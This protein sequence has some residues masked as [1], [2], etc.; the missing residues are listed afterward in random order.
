MG[1]GTKDSVRLETVISLS[2]EVTALLCAQTPMESTF[3]WH[4]QNTDI[5]LDDYVKARRVALGQSLSVKKL[6]YLDTN[7]WITLHEAAE[8]TDVEAI[9]FRLL[10]ALRN[11]V[12]TG[13]VL[14]PISANIFI[15]LMKQTD[16]RSRQAKA[17]LIDEL[18]QGVALMDEEERVSLEV[19]YFIQ[20]K[21]PGESLYPLE[22]LV[23]CKLGYVFGIQ[24]PT[25]TAFEPA[26]ERVIQKVCFDRMWSA[27]MSEIV[28]MVNAIEFTRAADFG[29]IA[30]ELN[31]SNQLYSADL[32]TFAKTNSDEIRGVID[33]QGAAILR[34][35]EFQAR[36]QGIAV[37]D[38]DENARLQSVTPFKNAMVFALEGNVKDARHTLRTLHIH[39]S[40]NASVR[41]NKSR[42][43]KPNDILDFHHAAAAL[44]YCDAF[45]KQRVGTGQISEAG[46]SSTTLLSF[47]V[48]S[49]LHA[50]EVPARQG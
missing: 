6:I 36:K 17:S 3:E 41:W 47:V 24:H 38:E 2:A 18:S 25:N 43:L 48:Y 15:E 50:H 40:L 39:A 21:L 9:E 12:A 32:K 20:S 27:P 46:V 1:G 14:C 33:L 28:A 13:L 35:V 42:K 49:L 23:W 16:A 37:Q 44:A 45:L 7:Y 30:E 19:S 34:T 4:Q 5:S 22:H 10:R 11:G 29:A 26:T 8:K 31:R